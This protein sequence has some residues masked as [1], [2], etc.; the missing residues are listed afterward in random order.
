[1]TRNDRAALKLAIEHARAQD[2]GRRQQ[3]DSMLADEPWEEVATFASYGCQMRSLRLRPWETPPAWVDDPQHPR[4]VD[5]AA[6]RLLRQMLA[7]GVSRWHPDPL[8]AIAEAK[9]RKGSAP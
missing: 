9:A 6:A 2:E 4:K 8:A 5:E 1:M 7:H 3:I